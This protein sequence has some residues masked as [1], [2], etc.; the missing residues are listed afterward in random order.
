MATTS[1]RRKS[2]AAKQSGTERIPLRDVTVTWAPGGLGERRFSG[3]DLARLLSYA[4]G[5]GDITLWGVFNND[6]GGAVKGLAETLATLSTGEELDSKAL[7]FLSGAAR[8]LGAKL[9]C[10][11]FGDTEASKHAEDF[12]LTITTSKVVA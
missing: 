5:Y 8:D 1:L 9:N 3:A 4:M 11:G 6:Q 2:P 12:V 10:P 7:L